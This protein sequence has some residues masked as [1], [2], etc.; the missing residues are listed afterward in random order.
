MGVSVQ[1]HAPGRFI[2]RERASG[3]YYVGDWVS[4]RVGLDM[5]SKRKI[6][7]PRQESNPDHLIVQLVASHYT[8]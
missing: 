1:V 2:P 8:D 7:N 4:P 5:V 3:I 6:P